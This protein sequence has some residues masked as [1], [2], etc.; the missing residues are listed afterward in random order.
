LSALLVMTAV[1][2]VAC[3]QTT[4]GLGGQ[5]QG[6][7]EPTATSSSGAPSSGATPTSTSTGSSGSQV[8][9]TPGQ[10]TVSLIGPAQG[11]R[12][13][14][15]TET[16]TVEIANGLSSTITAT[17]H[18]TSCTMVTLEQQVSGAWQPVGR[19][20]IMAATRMIPIAGG[21]A[22]KQILAPQNGATAHAWPAG[23][24]RVAFGY[25]VGSE[26][27]TPGSGATVYSAT[28]TIG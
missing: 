18:H 25:S 10:V 14:A 5:S 12:S 11:A 26:T 17:D 23:T 19:C 8:A 4:S 3:G 13:V 6:S 20:L 27:P 16:I 7:R 28:F 15:T 2:L 1:G 22:V 21:Q 24:Y 9:P